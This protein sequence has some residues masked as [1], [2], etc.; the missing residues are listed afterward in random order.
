MQGCLRPE[1][2]R[3][4][5]ARALQA[6]LPR[7][8]VAGL[9]PPSRSTRSIHA[10]YAAQHSAARA[11]AADAQQQ[12]TTRAAGCRLDGGTCVWIVCPGIVAGAVP[13]MILILLAFR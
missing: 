3:R 1:A 12:H 9:L 7:P 2:E 10:A 5:T 4:W 11:A 6:R 8:N 13:I